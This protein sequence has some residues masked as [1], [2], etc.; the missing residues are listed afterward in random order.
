MAESFLFCIADSLIKILASAAYEE[1]ARV[2][3]VYDDLH[4]FRETLRLVKAVLLDADQKREHNNELQEWLRQIKHI[5]SDAENVLDKFEYERSRKQAVKAYGSVKTKVGN[6]FSSSNPLVFRRK[7]AKQIK[8]MKKRLDKVA[9]D[10]HKFGLKTIDV[11]TRVVHKREMTYSTVIDSDVIGRNHD[12]EIVIKYLMQQIPSDEHHNL[13][14]IPIVGMG[15]LGK[16]TLAKFVFNDERISEY[17]QLKMWVCVSDDFDIKQLIIKII[18][19]ASADAP[20]HQQSLKELD[21]EQLQ[22]LLRNKLVDQMFLLVLDDVW[23]ED[24]VKWVELRNL[25]QVGAAGS[26]IL[27]TTR[28]LSI[29]SMMGTIPAYILEGLSMEDSLSLLK[30]WAFKEGE[31]EKYPTLIKV[32]REI[33]K[34]CGGVPLAM[35]T[36]GSLLFSKGMDEW[37]YVR[38]NEIWS[39]PQKKDDI[40]PALKLSYDQMPSYLR[41]CFAF[42]SLYPKDF[43]FNSFEVTSLWASLGLLPSPNKSQALE[44]VTNQYLCELLSRS[45]LQDFVPLGTS[46][47]FRIHDLV[48]DLAL[49]ISKDECLTMN[50]KIQNIHG[51]V[52]HLSFAEND[53]LAKSF[54]PNFV[55]V[56]TI[57]FPIRG[58]GA[59]SEAFLNMCVARFKYLR[60]LDLSDS[61]YK[62]LPRSI[63]KLGHLR[64]LNLS[65]NEKIKRVP[66]SICKLSNLQ[67][68]DLTQ[69]KELEALPKGL[70]YLINLQRLGITTKQSALPE[71]DI[72]NLS[73]LRFLKIDSCDNLDSLFAG[74]KLHS[75]KTLVVASCGSLQSLPFDI[76]HFSQLETLVIHNCGNLKLLKGLDNRNSNLRLK[77]IVLSSLPQLV[78]LSPWLQECANTLQY[79]SINDCENLEVLPDWLSTLSFLKSFK[80]E[81]CPKLMSLPNDI[82]CLT[83]LEYL[84]IHDCPGLCRKYK[85]QVGEYWPKICHI[86]RIIIQEPEELKDE[87]Y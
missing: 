39:L 41:Q 58:V 85:P 83:A 43:E 49:Y 9:A 7:M 59:S 21:I 54:T 30:K 10:R 27:V 67:V 36:I 42:F 15:G 73:F 28:S 79:L 75:L 26:K 45:F 13:S 5:F 35:R 86:K 84:K 14:I 65:R 3:G 24:R 46:Y 64:Y 74:I 82:H 71:N 69:C 32:G 8:E 33:M 25:I 66:E 62:T 18:N 87:S 48:H 50:S 57:L 60:I 1:A 22:N 78:T 12:K 53:F 47:S 38:D 16:T 76:N 37:E 56:R 4:E 2:I 55:G 17:F 31:E 40:L 44:D 63:C 6:F 72:A 77:V 80:I 52:Q 70:R 19:S 29:A 34:K 68:L 81:Y 11:D 51:N 23:N 61:A 20:A